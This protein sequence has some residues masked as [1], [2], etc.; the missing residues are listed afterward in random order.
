MTDDAIIS[1]RNVSKHFGRVVAVDD[2]SF[3]LLFATLRL[4]QGE[5]VLARIDFGQQLVALDL[6]FGASDLE[7][8]LNDLNLVLA[9]ANLKLRLGLFQVFLDLFYRQQGVFQ[10]GHALGVVK[11]EDQVAAGGQGTSGGELRDLRLGPDV[12]RCQR[13]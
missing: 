3:E 4:F 1:F 5:L 10:S 2:V 13:Q 7:V 8:R 12:R 11:F 6:K 9:L